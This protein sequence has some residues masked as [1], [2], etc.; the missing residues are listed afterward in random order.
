MEVVPAGK[1]LVLTVTVP[2]LRLNGPTAPR[3]PIVLLASSDTLP[4]APDGVTPIVT[5]KVVP[6]KT[7]GPL[8]LL[9]TVVVAVRLK[10]A[11]LLSRFATLTE[12]RPVAMS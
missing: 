7:G 11:Q 6:A 12:P 8:A 10:L 2:L 1:R 3:L 5:V 9:S 4:V